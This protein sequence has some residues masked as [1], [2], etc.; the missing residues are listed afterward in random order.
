MSNPS[1]TSAELDVIEKAIAHRRSLG[2]NRIKPEPVPKEMIQRCLEAANWAPSNG[3]TEPWRFTV[4]TGD[5][6]K[7]LGEAFARAYIAINGDE[8]KPNTIEAQR[9]RG[10]DS[11]VWIS[12]GMSPELDENGD[13]KESLEEELMAAACAAHNL[14]LM[15]CSQGLI[16]MWLSRNVMTHPEVAQYVGLTGP[17]D[18]LLGFMVFGFPN[19]EWPTGER[20]PLSEKVTWKS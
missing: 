20:K 5:S 13:L 12:I 2:V 15:A 7:E 8:A 17:H 9:N 16:G 1:F 3:D 11:P 14:H 19:V 10:S 4:I 6:R 18:R